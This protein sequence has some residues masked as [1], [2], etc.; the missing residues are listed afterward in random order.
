LCNKSRRLFGAT[1]P[2]VIVRTRSAPVPHA[3]SW[4]LLAS[5]GAIRKLPASNQIPP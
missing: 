2:S 4:W 1:V 3:V 5:V